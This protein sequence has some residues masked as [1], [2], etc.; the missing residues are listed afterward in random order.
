MVKAKI[1]VNKNTKQ[2]TVIIPKKKLSFL[3][4]R[5]PKF[6]NIDEEDFNF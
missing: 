6:L 4:N 5:K 2:L 3:K 1:F